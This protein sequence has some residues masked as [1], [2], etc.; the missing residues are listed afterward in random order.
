MQYVSIP[1]ES[2]VVKCR[3]WSWFNH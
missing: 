2:S 1:E 3:I